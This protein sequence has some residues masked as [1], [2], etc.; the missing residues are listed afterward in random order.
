MKHAAEEVVHDVLHPVE[1]LHRVQHYVHEHRE[2]AKEEAERGMYTA[3]DFQE[4][5]ALA[6]E[7]YRQSHPQGKQ[8]SP[9]PLLCFLTLRAVSTTAGRPGRRCWPAGAS[10]SRCRR[11]GMC[12]PHRLLPT[13]SQAAD[14]IPPLRAACLP[15]HAL[16]LLCRGAWATRLRMWRTKLAALCTLRST[17]WRMLCTLRS[18]KWRT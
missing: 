12:T 14:R 17:R 3:D 11:C 6:Q 5:A 15:A 9:L 16:R 7:A 4:A 1:T 10:C 18:T 2:K 13:L 8:V